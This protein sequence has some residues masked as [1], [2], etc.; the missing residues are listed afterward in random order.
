M[1]SLAA[2]AN[3]VQAL[4]VNDDP[5]KDGSPGMGFSI[6]EAT[7]GNDSGFTSFESSDRPTFSRG[8]LP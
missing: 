4:Q 1:L 2:T 7:R 5:Y 8:Q 3:G 6:E